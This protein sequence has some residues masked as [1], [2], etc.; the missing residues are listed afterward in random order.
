MG[1]D[2][3]EIINRHKDKRID[4]QYYMRLDK[5]EQVGRMLQEAKLFVAMFDEV[6]SN[7][8][9]TEIS[10]H[11]EILRRMSDGSRP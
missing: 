1:D 9:E 11:R 8:S 5:D 6:V 7:L 10:A 3:T 4:A 2:K